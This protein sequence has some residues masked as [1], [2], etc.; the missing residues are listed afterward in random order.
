MLTGGTVVLTTE[1]AL[2]GVK[3][4]D[5]VK[6][7]VASMPEVLLMRAQ[8]DVRV[9]HTGSDSDLAPEIWISVARF[10]YEHRND[11]SGFL[12]IGSIETIPYLGNS[13]S[14]MI[15]NP[16]MPVILTGSQLPDYL[17]DIPSGFSDIAAKSGGVGLRANMI[18]AIQTVQNK[19]DGC[20]VV[21]GD[22]VVAS[23][24]V[25]LSDPFAA[26][27]F[28]YHSE[29]MTNK[30]EFSIKDSS[31]VL[32][33]VSAFN[34][35]DTVFLPH[36]ELRTRFIEVT[37]LLYEGEIERILEGAEGALFHIPPTVSL[38]KSLFSFLASR[39]SRFPCVVFGKSLM[40]P[41]M[42]AMK[43]LRDGLLK[44]GIILT[45]ET[46]KAWVT[47]AFMWALGKSKDPERL[48]QL[49]P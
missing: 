20:Y 26:F 35:K 4:E 23:R 28:T 10:I 24:K 47:T 11:Y 40:L 18:N 13:I 6:R 21:F 17:L 3:K 45:R 14:L 44:Q 2:V 25:E 32:E 15:E 9:F 34:E 27:P 39:K 33:V 5:D 46:G 38:P 31:D 16:G 22:R 29:P 36:M 42:G 41:E 8:I 19:V 30:V 43:K 12:I 49:L 37:P 7:W 1:G 48:R